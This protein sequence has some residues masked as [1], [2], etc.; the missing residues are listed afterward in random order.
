MLCWAVLCRA[1]PC[2][3][4]LCRGA[5][6]SVVL[7]RAVSCRGVSCRGVAG[8]AVLCR[9]TLFCAVLCPV[10]GCLVSV[11]FTAVRCG[12]VCRVASCCAVFRCAVVCGGPSALPFRRGVVSALVRLVRFLV[13]HAGRGY[14][15]GSWPRGGVRCGVARWICVAGARWAVWLGGSG[16]FLRGC[17][18]W[19]PVPWSRVLWGS[20]PL[21]VCLVLWGRASW[22]PQVRWVPSCPSACLPSLVL[23]SRP[24]PLVPLVTVPLPVWW[25]LLWTGSSPGDG[26][27]V[28]GCAAVLSA[29]PPL[30]VA[31]TSRVGVPSFPCAGSGGWWA[32]A[33]AVAAASGPCCGGTSWQ[34]CAS[35]ARAVSTGVEAVLVLPLWRALLACAPWCPSL[36]P[37]PL[38]DGP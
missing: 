22:L 9:D 11:R 15:A 25:P 19:G 21:G 7:C 38:C 5:L 28:L 1:A 12:A 6:C 36:R 26:G 10:V 18:P 35:G 14:V 24:C 16:G 27:V 17:P 20:L 31:P 23:A 30:G 4:L 34:A 13:R 2:W 8:C 32:R 3:S 33:G 37:L 29:T